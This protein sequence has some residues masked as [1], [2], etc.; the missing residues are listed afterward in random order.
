M[1]TNDTIKA[2][3]VLDPNMVTKIKKGN[4]KPMK[5][6]H[7]RGGNS[8]DVAM[9]ELEAMLKKSRKRP[10]L[11][12]WFTDGYTHARPAKPRNIKHM[13]WVIYDNLNFEVTDGSRVIHIKSEDLGR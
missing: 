5:E 12:M 10:E 1:E 4:A 7:G 8:E 6:I 2:D 11:V 13:I 3:G 9:K